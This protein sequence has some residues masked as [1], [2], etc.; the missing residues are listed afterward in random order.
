MPETGEPYDVLQQPEY[1]S[2]TAPVPGQAVRLIPYPLLNQT[3][4]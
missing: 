4:G 2:R 1:V 3:L